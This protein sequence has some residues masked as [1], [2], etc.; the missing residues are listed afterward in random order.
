MTIGNF[1]YLAREEVRWL[2]LLLAGTAPAFRKVRLGFT[3]SNF[4]GVDEFSLEI[5]DNFLALPT[6]SRLEEVALTF[7][8]VSP[9]KDLPSAVKRGLRH[10]GERGVLRAEFPAYAVE[11]EK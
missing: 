11:A 3:S 9:Q 5:L 1:H 7:G 2:A 6:F 8:S 10:L 4:E